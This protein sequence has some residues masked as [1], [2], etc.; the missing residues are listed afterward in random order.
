MTE[1]TKDTKNKKQ[2]DEVVEE[3]TETEAV[4]EVVGDK[5][6]EEKPQ[7]KKKTASKKSADKNQLTNQPI[8]QSTKDKHSK[9]YREVADL[10]EKE[11]LY[12]A[13]EGLSLAKKT[14]TTKF[15]STVEVHISLG[16][17]MK[18]A[19]QQVRGSMVLPHGTGK[20]KTVVAIVGPE[21]EKESK[22][23]GAVEAGGAELVEKIVKGWTDFDVII[24]T[25]DMMAILGKAAKVLGPKGLMPNPKA[26]TVT[27][28]PAKTIKSIKGGMVEYRAD[29]F[30]IIHQ[31]IGKVSFDDAKLKENYDALLDTIKKAKPS[32]A[33]GTYI[34][35]IHIAT[36]MGPSVKVAI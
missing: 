12:T 20:E 22:E 8:N 31:A 14:A 10:I 11:N 35:S 27:P 30:G 33:K 36:T 34:K 21:K 25:P 1:E 28:D 7:K 19:D 6:T 5:T 24:S 17:D 29:T 3:T 15:D 32:A 13:E 26:G 16:I 18:K 2:K 23:A 9:K 4:K